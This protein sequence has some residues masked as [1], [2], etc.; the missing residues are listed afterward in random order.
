MG[1]DN[2]T[3]ENNA[4]NM[5]ATVVLYSLDGDVVNWK[6]ENDLVYVITIKGLIKIVI[7]RLLRLS[8]VRVAIIAGTLQPKPITRGINDLPCRPA[9]CIN[10]SIINAARAIYPE[11]SISEMNR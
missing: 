2:A 7:R 9:K 10:L 1:T 3:E 5:S 11:S 4:A 6:T 8:I